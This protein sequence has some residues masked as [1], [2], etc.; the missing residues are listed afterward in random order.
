MTPIT[1]FHILML[2]FN[3]AQGPCKF[4]L[5]SYNG[6]KYFL[7]A[8]FKPGAGVMYYLVLLEVKNEEKVK[9]I[10]VFLWPGQQPICPFWGSKQN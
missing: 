3:L 8:F 6:K 1:K 2:L 7:Q 4:W 5:L 10:F 9:N